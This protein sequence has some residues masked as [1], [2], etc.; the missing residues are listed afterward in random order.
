MKSP[1]R[2]VLGVFLVTGAAAGGAA[3]KQH[4]G[5]FGLWMGIFLGA[6]AGWLAAWWVRH[7]FLDF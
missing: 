1:A 5:T 6:L 2:F 3:G 7:N 4:Y